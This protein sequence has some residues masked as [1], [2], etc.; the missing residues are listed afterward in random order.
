MMGNTGGS[1]WGNDM[2]GNDWFNNQRQQQG[3]QINN[4][5]NFNSAEMADLIQQQII[6]I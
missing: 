5:F 2:Q 6:Q 1:G 3:F 4:G